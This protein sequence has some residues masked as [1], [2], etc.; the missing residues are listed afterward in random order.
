MRGG[1]M[2]KRLT[3]EEKQRRLKEAE[4]K[5]RIAKERK[6]QKAEDNRLTEE[7]IAD[8]KKLFDYAFNL[9]GYKSGQKIGRTMAL[10]IERLRT[11]Q[12]TGGKDTKPY[13]YKM[14]YYTF[15]LKAPQIRQSLA[16]V[17]FK[18]EQH[19]LNYIMVIVENNIND[20]YT[21]IQ[22][23]KLADEEIKN[24]TIIVNVDAPNR[25]QKKRE[26]KSAELFDDNMW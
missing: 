19:K 23:K 7:E 15:V 14:I 5:K 9:L 13:D 3:E 8:R 16:T 25:Y 22:Q 10:R 12:S 24:K 1:S 17:T 6:K 4:E 21:S 2:G 18:D 20:V 11:G 26:P